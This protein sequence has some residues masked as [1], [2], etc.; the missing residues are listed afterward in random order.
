MTQSCLTYINLYT[1]G[2][3]P[4]VLNLEWQKMIELIQKGA[5][6]LQR[7]VFSFYNKPEGQKVSRKLGNIS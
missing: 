7:E 6:F 3:E 5:F 1:Y 2:S 4:Q